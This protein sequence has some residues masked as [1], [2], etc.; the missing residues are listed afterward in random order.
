MYKTW[1]LFILYVIYFYI[2]FM[3]LIFLS[4]KIGMGILLHN[5]LELSFM[6]C[7]DNT[8]LSKQKLVTWTTFSENFSC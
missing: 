1:Q 8:G 6:L 5:V 4:I 2:C 3:F 7:G